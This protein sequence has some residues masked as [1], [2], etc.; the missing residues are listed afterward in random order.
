MIIEIVKCDKCG[1]EFSPTS[2]FYIVDFAYAS[3][4]ELKPHNLVIKYSNFNN[5][6]IKDDR[7]IIKSFD[8]CGLTC[9]TKF[10]GEKL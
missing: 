10:L 4:T 5:A 1:T 9:L 8:I 6:F 2:E 3:E 7:F